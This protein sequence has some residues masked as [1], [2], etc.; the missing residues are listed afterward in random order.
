MPGRLGGF[1]GGGSGVIGGEASAV[2]WAAGTSTMVISRHASMELTWPSIQTGSFDFSTF[3][4][5]QRRTPRRKRTTRKNPAP[6]RRFVRCGAPLRRSEGKGNPDNFQRDLKLD[7]LAPVVEGKE[8]LLV[9]AF[10]ARDIREAVEFCEKQKVRMIL[11]GASEAWKTIDLL[12][13]DNIPV[14]IGPVL[15]MPSEDDSYDSNTPCLA[16]FTPQESDRIR[17]ARRKRRPCRF[18]AH[19]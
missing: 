19:V 12:K 6:A 8:P 17:Q 4:F 2:V 15:S 16:S 3:S 13:K 10:Q 9:V 18:A 14:I 1:G 5:T 11:A 7:A